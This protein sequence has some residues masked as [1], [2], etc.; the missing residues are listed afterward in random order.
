VQAVGW[1][2]LWGYCGLPES[3]PGDLSQCAGSR[4]GRYAPL[5]GYRW[6]DLYRFRFIF[7]QVVG[8]ERACLP[9]FHR[10][11][12]RTEESMPPV[13]QECR[14][15]PLPGNDLISGDEQDRFGQVGTVGYIRRSR[16]P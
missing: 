10:F 12:D 11:H 2:S 7:C 13:Y 4:P 15:D 3:S 16:R 6:S 14:L 8:T 5:F 9:G 1:Q